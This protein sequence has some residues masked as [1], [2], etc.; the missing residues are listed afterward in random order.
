MIRS[1][2]ETHQIAFILKFC[3]IIICFGGGI[4]LLISL[5]LIYENIYEFIFLLKKNW[6]MKLLRRK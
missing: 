4:M 1:L 3:T 2:D 5:K 6:K